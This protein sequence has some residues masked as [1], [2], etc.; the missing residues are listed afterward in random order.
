MIIWD[1]A[2]KVFHLDVDEV[3]RYSVQFDPE[4]RRWKA[5]LNNGVLPGVEARSAMDVRIQV[6]ERIEGRGTDRAVPEVSDPTLPDNGA[7]R[8]VENAK[9]DS[10]ETYP[11]DKYRPPSGGDKKA[12]HSHVVKIDGNTYT[13]LAPSRSQYA[14]KT[15]TVS[16]SWQWNETQRY[17]NIILET[18][19]VRHKNGQEVVRGHRG[20]KP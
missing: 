9:I 4:V 1:K 20:S 10:Y 7:I 2:G 18:L 8:S 15:D 12:W 14:Y 3:G 13:F 17:R 11:K 16:F 5:Y 19:E 6:E